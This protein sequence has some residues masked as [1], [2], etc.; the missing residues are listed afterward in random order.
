MNVTS[1]R[2]TW[3]TIKK[4]SCIYDIDLVCSFNTH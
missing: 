4:I 2:Q 1:V 3:N